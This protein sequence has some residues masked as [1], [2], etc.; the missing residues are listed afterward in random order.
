MLGVSA[1]TEAWLI[2]GAVVLIGIALG[3][4]GLGMGIV[5]TLLY[6]LLLAILVLASNK[7]FSQTSTR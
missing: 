5:G 1:M 6:T 3:A 7:L 2:V 4:A